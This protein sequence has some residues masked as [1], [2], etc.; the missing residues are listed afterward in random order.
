YSSFEARAVEWPE[1]VR[2]IHGLPGAGR[3]AAISPP[4]SVDAAR[5]LCPRRLSVTDHRAT[6]AR[7]VDVR[8]G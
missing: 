1:Y 3:S 6:G 5:Q 2:I 8:P 4:R 7:P